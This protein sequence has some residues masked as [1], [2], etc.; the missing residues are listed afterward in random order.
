MNKSNK[1]INEV[2]I[3]SFIMSNLSCAHVTAAFNPI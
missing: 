3:A 1:G 2:K